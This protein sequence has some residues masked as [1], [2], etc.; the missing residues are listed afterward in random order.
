MIR[1]GKIERNSISRAKMFKRV[2]R[3]K[4]KTPII[5]INISIFIIEI[6][7]MKNVGSNFSQ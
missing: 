3:Q 1:N 4:M 5:I 7:G 2:N 6:Q